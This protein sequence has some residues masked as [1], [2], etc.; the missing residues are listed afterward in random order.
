MCKKKLL[1]HTSRPMYYLPQASQYRSHMSDHEGLLVKR[2][3][4]TVLLASIPLPW[5]R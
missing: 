5:R 2:L 1:L 3:K 4:H